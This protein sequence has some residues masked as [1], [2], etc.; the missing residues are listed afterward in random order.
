[1][2]Q[3]DES[4]TGREYYDKVLTEIEEVIQTSSEAEQGGD[5]PPRE[6]TCQF[7]QAIDEGEKRRVWMPHG[8][9]IDD[10]LPRMRQLRYGLLMR[11][12]PR[13]RPGLGTWDGYH[14]YHG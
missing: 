13:D 9:K 5:I 11:L 12:L 1:M 7:I 2:L 14:C 4:F 10:M 3:R 6:I 8:Q